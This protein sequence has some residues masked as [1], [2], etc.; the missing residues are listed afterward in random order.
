MRLKYAKI[1]KPSAIKTNGVSPS[2]NASTMLK[3]GKI[4]STPQIKPIN[5]K[6]LGIRGVILDGNSNLNVQNIASVGKGTNSSNCNAATV[7]SIISRAKIHINGT[8]K[9]ISNFM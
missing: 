8:M 1:L 3:N 9:R 6:N 5:L 2:N 7:R 4:F